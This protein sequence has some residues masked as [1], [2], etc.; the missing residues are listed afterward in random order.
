MGP[1]ESCLGGK[2]GL[3]I[4]MQKLQFFSLPR[5]IQE[6]FIESTRG[7]GAPKPLLYHSPANHRRVL[8]LAVTASFLFVLCGAIARIGFGDLNHRWALNPPYVIVAYSG[9]LCSACVSLIGAVRGWNRELN[10]P[11]RPGVYLFPVGVINAQGAT[12]EFHPVQEVVELSH[13]GTCL[14]MRF[15]GAACFNFRRVDSRRADEIKAILQDAEQQL[16]SSTSELSRRDQALLDP[17]F[18]T[19]YKNPFSPHESMRP[20]A[21]ARNKHWPLLAVVIGAVVAGLGLWQWRNWLS[22]QYIYNHARAVGTPA[23]YRAYLARGGARADVRELLLPKAELREAQSAGTVEAIEH[24]LDSHPQS[25]IASDIEAALRES[26]L[27]ELNQASRSG[28]LPALRGFRK[29]DPHLGLIRAEVEAAQKN[30][31]QSALNRF[32]S[33]SKNS[34]ELE[35]FF[36]KL[37]GYAEQ[38]GPKVEIRFR[39]RVPPSFER[40]DAQVRESPYCDNTT[41]PPAQYFDD[42][43]LTKREVPVA[44]AI[45]DRFADAF[46]RD[47]LSF[48]LAP[49]LPDD[50]KPVPNVATP[51]L[52]ITYR[53]ELSSPFTSRKPKGVFVGVGIVFKAHLLIPGE[54]SARSFDFST[55]SPPDLKKLEAEK[56][57]PAEL[58]EFVAR[59]ALAQFL[60]RYLAS[61]F[62]AP[63]LTR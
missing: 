62:R 15:S 61:L 6:R 49:A 50:G 44:A 60:K 63:L 36:E 7:N 24:Y 33:L 31:Y 42:E 2:G 56:W 55:W 5:P 21:N 1:P 9:L 11:F 28:T 38:H 12:L 53:T 54:P 26:L 59:D 58:Y 17:L 20:A 16:K 47:I 8:V 13:H 41:M 3:A 35:T 29:N 25:K 37:L 43:H 10:V 30:L 48:E 39:R 4:R 40:A 19:G 34:P 23:A 18:D 46:S 52:L 51:T 45:S 32:K 14:R 22:A 27:R 57:G